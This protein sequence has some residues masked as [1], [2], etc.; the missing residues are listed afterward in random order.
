MN[1]IRLK[2]KNLIRRTEDFSCHQNTETQK[3]HQTFVNFRALEL[4]WLKQEA[5]PGFTFSCFS[6][7][8]F[9][10]FSFLSINNLTGQGTALPL[11]N[12]AYHILDRLEIKTG[13]PTPYHSSLKYYTRGAATSYALLIDTSAIALSFRDRLDLYYIFKDNNE[14]LGQS[15]FATT[16]GGKKEAPLPGT[17]LTQMEASYENS[18]Y[19]ESRNPFLKYFYRSPANFVEVNDKYFHLRANPILN[20]SMAAAKDLDEPVLFNQRGIE[21]RGGVDDRIYFYMNILETQAHFPRYVDERIARDLAVPGAGLFKDYNSDIFGVQN[22]YDYLNGQG[23]MAFNITR[24]VG[25]Q[26][27]YGRNF[28][29][30]GYRSL[31]LS[32]FAHNYLY[33]KLNWKVWKIHYQNIFAELSAETDKQTIGETVIAKKYM[34]AHHLSYNILPNLT[35]GIFEA[36]IFSRENQFEFQYL[37]PVIFYRTIEQGLGS[38]DNVLIGFDA[39]YNFLNH[40]QLYAQFMLDEFLFDELFVES[41]GWW[42]NKFGWQLGLKY[43][44]ALGI[45]HFDL[46]A[47]INTIRPY[48]YSHRDSSGVYNHYNTPL[49]HPLGANFREYLLMARY[50]PIKKLTIDTRLI[51]AEF[52]EDADSTNWGGNLILNN[53]SREKDFGNEIGQGINAKSL[54]AGIDL[55]YQIRHNVFLELYYFYRK[56]NSEEDKRDQNVQYFGGGVRVNIG[57]QRMDF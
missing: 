22:G 33:L 56:K 50:T 44:D 27:G 3:L 9:F 54:L 2:R 39:K 52:G 32:D 34:A 17:E 24:H 46:Q 6:M 8:V 43:I 18:R 41:N 55:S 51:L 36:V 29:G 5:T 4:P 25:M 53:D 14:W 47:E 21:M 19:I 28:I 10:F 38:P 37:N 20:F 16:I 30:N 40:C 31:L 11:G 15:Y 12:E 35:L 48:T 57:K 7:A 13:L 49:A 1:K 26:F 23:Y 42:A 45:D